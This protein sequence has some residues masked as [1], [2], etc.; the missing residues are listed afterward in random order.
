[1][2]FPNLPGYA[3]R[4][5]A[6]EISQRPD[7]VRRHDLQ[8]VDEIGKEHHGCSFVDDDPHRSALAVGAH[9]DQ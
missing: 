6:G 3:G 8:L 9:E 7:F 1:M 5:I 2:D 4:R